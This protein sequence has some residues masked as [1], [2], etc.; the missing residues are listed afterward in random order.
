MVAYTKPQPEP[1]PD[2]G[3]SI[4]RIAP[5]LRGRSVYGGRG[6]GTGSPSPPR[7]HQ[8]N[9]GIDKDGR[10]GMY[11]SDKSNLLLGVLPPMPMT[12][13]RSPSRR[14]RYHG[15][16]C[17]PRHRIS[18]AHQAMRGS[19]S[20]TERRNSCGSEIRDKT[21]AWRA[22]IRRDG[23][24]VHRWFANKKLSRQL[25]VCRMGDLAEKVTAALGSGTGGY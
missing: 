24:T 2:S 14:V 11:V 25:D 21:L 7:R 22:E 18:D 15:A 1:F 3:H 4:D 6:L 17:V 19:A 8:S 9:Y 20:V 10:V 16:V 12:R 5:S 23:V 13:G